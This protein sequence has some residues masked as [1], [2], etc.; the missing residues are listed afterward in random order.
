MLQELPI[1]IMDNKVPGICSQYFATGKDKKKVKV[2][3]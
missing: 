3:M 2:K 1:P